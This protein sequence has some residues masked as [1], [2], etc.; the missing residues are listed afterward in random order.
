MIPLNLYS[1]KTEQ[2][3]FILQQSD[4]RL[5]FFGDEAINILER[6]DLDNLSYADR[7]LCEAFCTRQYENIC[8]PHEKSH[9]TAY[10]AGY[11]AHKLCPKNLI[12]SH[13]SDHLPNREEQLED[14]KK[15]AQEK[16]DG[17]VVVP[18]DNDTIQL[19]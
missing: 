7:L 4:K 16:F 10:E 19:R 9:I 13:I 1:K 14:I 17:T 8:K 15:E 12:L 11:I 18:Y 3:G 6:S 5:I 2:Y